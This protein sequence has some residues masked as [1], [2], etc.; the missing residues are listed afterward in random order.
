VIPILAENG[1][2]GTRRADDR[3]SNAHRQLIGYTGLALPVT[4]IA[5]TWL[6]PARGLPRWGVLNSISAYFYTSA[7]AAFVGLL[8]AL[9][10]F[11]FTYR[12]YANELGWADRAASNI[13]GVAALGVAVFPTSAP[14][15]ELEVPW[16]A[17]WMVWVHYGSAI[18]LF[19]MFAVFSLWLF[20]KTGGGPPSSGKARRNRIYLTCGLVIVVG[21]AWTAANALTGHCIFLPETVVLTAFAVSWLTK[22]YALRS[23]RDAVRSAAS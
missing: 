1:S 8:V 12:G 6:I 5:M 7:N 13:A 3:S 4:L 19:S 11:L 18:L 23:I 15:P 16:W 22:G 17:G 14:L 2:P 21:I 10:L 20:R 9:A